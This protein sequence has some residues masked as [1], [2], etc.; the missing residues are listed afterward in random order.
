MRCRHG[1]TLIEILIVIFIISI[2][3]TVAILS[4]GRSHHQRLSAMASQVA[5][6]MTLAEEQ[7]MLQPAVMGMSISGQAIQFAVYQAPVNNKGKPSWL[8][9]QEKPL[10]PHPIPDDMVLVLTLNGHEAMDEKNAAQPVVISTSG[11]ITPFTLSIGMKGREPE[12]VVRG[13]ADGTITTQQ[14]R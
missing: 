3:S 6:L 8:P 5:Q 2:V 7:A 9:W 12:Y 1:Y 4:I 10:Q 13:E 14:R 11:D